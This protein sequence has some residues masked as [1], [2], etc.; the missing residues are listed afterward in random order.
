MKGLSLSQE[1]V[2]YLWALNVFDCIVRIP[3]NLPSK[4]IWTGFGSI[5]VPSIVMVY[6]LSVVGDNSKARQKFHIRKFCSGLFNSVLPSSPL[7]NL[8]L[9]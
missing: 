2:I 3:L 9:I 7:L 5:C 4:D 6:S 1:Y 8:F